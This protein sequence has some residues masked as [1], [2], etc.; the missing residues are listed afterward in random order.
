MAPEEDYNHFRAARVTAELHEAGV[1]VGIGAHGQREGL[2]A[3]WEMWMLEQGG[4]SPMNVLRAATI[5]GARH[6]GLDGD[7]G[8]VEPGKLADIIVLDNDPLKDLRQSESLTHVMI[9]GRLYDA[10]TM[11]E[12][13]GPARPAFWWEEPSK[14]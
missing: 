3:H 14:P 2:A 11:N 12:V 10:W 8:S 1:A 7:I 4:M 9:N 13:D 6:L 5:D